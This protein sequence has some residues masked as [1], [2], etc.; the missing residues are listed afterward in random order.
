MSF[1]SSSPL[2]LSFNNG[3]LTLIPKKQNANRIAD[4]RPISCCNTVYKAESKLL[5]ERLKQ[6]LPLIISNSQSVFIPGRL[7]VEN[8]LMATEL[9]QGYNWKKISK[10][11]MLKVDLKKSFDSINW[12]YIVLILR[13]LGFPEA[14]VNLIFQCISTTRFSVAINGELCGYFKGARGLRQGDPLSPYLFV[15]A[16]EV[17]SQMI[18]K[19]FASG[20]IGYHPAASNPFVTH[21]AF[22]DDIMIFLWSLQLSSTNL[23]NNGSVFCMVWSD[24]EP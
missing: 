1:M 4:F 6:T 13:A 15:L 19:E 9:I 20:M 3:T 2:D 24:N 11:S 14:F 5:A 21:L 10:G 18:N 16:M 12:S 8:V 23:S 7:L 22:A 17:F